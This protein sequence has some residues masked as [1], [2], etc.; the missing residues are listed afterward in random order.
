[1]ACRDVLHPFVPVDTTPPEL[2]ETVRKAIA[3]AIETGELLQ[4]SREAR[5]ISAA[6]PGV[7]LTRLVHL[8]L[9]AAVSARID[10]E[11]APAS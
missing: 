1:M 3:R 4:V 2:H 10:F 5:R 9:E 8:L 7:P 11:I 6:L